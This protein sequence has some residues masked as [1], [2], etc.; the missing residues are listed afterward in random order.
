LSDHEEG[1]ASEQQR[2]PGRLPDLGGWV[3]VQIQ[4]DKRLGPCRSSNG[5]TDQEEDKHNPQSV[6]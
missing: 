6:S 2:H 3:I 1:D 5:L 4:A